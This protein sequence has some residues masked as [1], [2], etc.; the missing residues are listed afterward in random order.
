MVLVKVFQIRMSDKAIVFRFFDEQGNEL[1]S[2]GV[3]AGRDFDEAL[4]DE[5]VNNMTISEFYRL[6]TEGFILPDQP[7]TALEQ[8]AKIAY[9]QFL[10]AKQLEEAESQ[11]VIE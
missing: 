1:G 8:V 6:K 7:S 2:R 3:N 5:V 4:F 9:D 11:A 10:Q